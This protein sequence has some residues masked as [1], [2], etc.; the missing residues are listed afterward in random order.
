MVQPQ[1]L[2]SGLLAWGRVSSPSLFIETCQ[3]DLGSSGP[4]LCSLPSWATC[5][6]LIYKR[7]RKKNLLTSVT[8]LLLGLCSQ[9]GGCAENAWISVHRS[10]WWGGNLSLRMWGRAALHAC[11]ILPAGQLGTLLISQEKALLL[12]WA[13]G[14]S[15][16]SLCFT[17]DRKGHHCR[18]KGDTSDTWLVCLITRHAVSFC[19]N[20]DMCFKL[21]MTE[22]VRI[23]VWHLSSLWMY[24]CWD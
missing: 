9:E 6:S 7:K 5:L 20:Y 23:H 17:S 14:A 18:W 24:N 3:P 8:C 11:L 2:Q 13:E 15:G 22:S 1:G 21:W 10:D 12:C 4:S 19:G 16:A